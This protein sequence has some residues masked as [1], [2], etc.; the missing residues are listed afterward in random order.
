ML[1]MANITDRMNKDGLLD[2]YLEE[3][4]ET[5]Q[6]IPNQFPE[7]NKEQHSVNMFLQLN[8]QVKSNKFENR[9]IQ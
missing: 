3:L 5:E 1:K 7:K 2:D 9:S 4:R 6:F 8:E